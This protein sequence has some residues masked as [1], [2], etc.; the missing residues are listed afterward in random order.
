MVNKELIDEI[1]RNNS[2]VDT[3]RRLGLELHRVGREYRSYSIYEPG[4]NDTCTIFNQDSEFFYDFKAGC[5]G[6]VID[7]VAEVKFNGNKGEAINELSGGKAY[8]QNDEYKK[9]VQDLQTYI[10]KWHEALRPEDIDYLTGRGLTLECINKM[11]LGYNAKEQR[12]IIP[13]FERGQVIYYCGRDMSGQ[14]TK[15][16]IK[17]LL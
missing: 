17:K 5:G 3:A 14:N 2:I 6:D 7:L 8:I 16:N 11:L 13:Y 10:N 9:Y 15:T 4:K 12:L 1:K